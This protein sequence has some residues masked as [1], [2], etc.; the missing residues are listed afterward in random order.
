MIIVVDENT[1]T[2]VQKKADLQKDRFYLRKH[3]KRTNSKNYPKSRIG[4]LNQ[5][6]SVF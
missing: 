3:Q 1:Y 4:T 2:Y 6:L 5:K